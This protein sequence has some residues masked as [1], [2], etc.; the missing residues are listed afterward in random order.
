MYG[1]YFYALTERHSSQKYREMVAMHG[2]R[3]DINDFC[4]GNLPYLS[5]Y[6]HPRLLG[7][8]E[9]HFDSSPSRSDIPNDVVQSAPFVG[10][11]GETLIIINEFGYN[12]NI[13]QRSDVSIHGEDFQ[14]LK[15]DSVTPSGEGLSRKQK[16]KD[17]ANEIIPNID[18]ND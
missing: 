6:V 1:L 18:L 16:G 13:V 12:D 9:L 8:A 17:T 5:N 11:N 7:T 10:E 2:K 14:V 4:H 3:L 15:Q